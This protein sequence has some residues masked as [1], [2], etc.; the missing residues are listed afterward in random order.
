[1]RRLC[2]RLFHRDDLVGLDR[3]TQAHAVQR[4]LGQSRFEC[5]HPVG[6]FLRIFLAEQTQHFLDMRV[7]FFQQYFRFGILANVVV[8][9]RQAEPALTGV[10][11]I[12]GR[13]LQVG[14][15]AE[16]EQHAKTQRLPVANQG[17]DVGCRFYRVDCRQIFLDR[18]DAGLIDC[19]LIH[20]SR[21]KIADLLR[22]AAWRAGI[23][24]RV[25][26]Y[27]LEQCEVAFLQFVIEAPRAVFRRNRVALEPAAIGVLPEIPARADAGIVV[28][29][30]QAAL[31]GRCASAHAQAAG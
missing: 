16:F 17:H 6:L 2:I 31:V 15:G 9:I 29:R 23:F 20:R 3:I 30:I 19:G 14:V 21:V 10:G 1:M 22:G 7:V 13:I 4:C 5:E 18:R 24:R 27:L 8:A 12:V 11:D 26:E 25:F 28:A